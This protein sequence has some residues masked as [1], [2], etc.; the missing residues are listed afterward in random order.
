MAL[1]QPYTRLAATANA[2]HGNLL[3]TTLPHRVPP[4][5]AELDALNA[6]LADGN[7]LLVMAA[8]DDTPRWALGA[9]G[10]LLRTLGRM[11]RLTFEAS[12]DPQ[13]PAAVPPGANAGARPNPDRA[14][15]LVN[16]VKRLLDPQ[17][18]LLEPKAPHPLFSTVHSVLAVSE[19][20]ASHWLA[21][22][23]DSHAV[24]EL[25]VRS[26]E[27]PVGARPEPAAPGPSEPAAW[28]ERVGAGQVI[29]FGAASPFSNG[30]IAAKDNARL[31]SNI[32][33]W[34]RG[35]GGAVLFDDDHQGAHAYYDAKA[36]FHDPRLRRTLLWILALWLMF[37]LGAQRLRPWE[38]EWH[39][40]DTTGFIGVTGGFL[41]SSL[42]P[43]AAG[44][45]LFN[46][47]FND[48]RRNL[49]LNEDGTPVWERLAAD[50]RIS[51]AS[52]N[53]LE[54]LHRR[55]SAGKPVDLRHLHNL[56][57]RLKGTLE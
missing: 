17:R 44:G 29:V 37:V 5:N 12:P 36:F 1:R 41:A 28:L 43:A 10:A 21:R 35:R 47:F 11:T 15:R 26:A 31:M 7:S 24:L 13:V 3:I 23:M 32:V 16:G 9:D 45:R 22:G 33:A 42:S 14:E 55:T 40:A 49:G 20:P 54:R 8:L 18:L 4:R 52:L 38:D 27:A 57:T 46:N 34:T 19:F 25:G 6:W 50:A 56:L 2:A 30:L 53:E 39:P 51:P 48:V